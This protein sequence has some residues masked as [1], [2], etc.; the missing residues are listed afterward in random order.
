[1]GDPVI[2]TGVGLGLAVLA[3]W[4]RT[5]GERELT[6]VRLIF[7]RDIRPEQVVAF[8]RSLAGLLP[9]WWRRVF[10]GTPAVIFEVASDER[11]IRHRLIAAPEQAG[12]V[13][14]QLQAAVPGTR[15]EPEDLGPLEVRASAEL[16]VS[17]THV[18]LRT[19]QPE[20]AV[21]G[22]LA[23]LQPRRRGE[24]SVI[25]WVLSPAPPGGF[26]GSV[27][28]PSLLAEVTLG[29]GHVQASLPVERARA[30]RDKRSEPEAH[31]VCRLGVRARDPRREVQLLRRMIGAFYAGNA[32]GVSFRVRWLPTA[33][34]ARRIE[35]RGQGGWTA[36]LNAKE[37]AA[38]LGIPLGDLQ[39]PGLTLGGARQL[40][41]SSELPRRG[42][43]LGRST[44][45]G[46]ER[47]LALK[48]ADSLRHLHVIGPTG[49]GKSTLLLNLIAGDMAAGRG[50]VVIDPKGD[51]VGDVL[52]RVPRDRV[53]D[54]ILLDPNDVDRPA[55]LNLL[56]GASEAPELVTDQVVSVFHHLFSAFWGPRT[57]DIL[58][59]ALLTLAAEPGM[60]LVEVPLLLT[61]EA[62]RRR[63]VAAVDDPV[64]LE[65]FWG[66]YE[67]MSSAE[68]A[69]AIGP[70]LNKL[71][72]FLL[73]RRLRNVI[74]QAESTFDLEAVLAERKIL[75]VNLAKGLL[76]EEAAALL[77]SA[78]LARL[79]QAV[80]ARAALP[81]S[82]RTPVF[83][84][85]DEFQDYLNLP[86]SLADVLAQARGY[87][88]GLTLAHQ[89][90]GQL[91]PLVRTA[92]LAN[93]RSKV[94]FQTAASDAQTLAREFAP[95]LTP[96][97]LQALGPYE[98][99]VAAAASNRVL[100]PASM[101]TLPPT[102]PTGNG[103]EARERSR[104]RYGRDRADIERAMRTR[105]ETRPVAGGVKRRRR[106]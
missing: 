51:L 81:P 102:E 44:F 31:A 63:M 94:V 48:V 50:V 103:S 88:F 5:S 3:L 36:R 59:A 98:A 105:L 69:Q 71:R 26:R 14:S 37:L 56:A 67:A 21:A 33:V 13:L 68:R 46:D 64:A 92:V 17:S 29:V 84:Y 72:T 57:D 53:G 104:L 45:P 83:C 55:G 35:R 91:P 52:D 42:R 23:T 95:H 99:V 62:F 61:D 60:T 85:V 22:L 97:D 19:D 6:A 11:G 58:R 7:P 66:W 73:R 47:V 54:V 8:A 32:P 86:T 80:Q 96:A 76:G 15:V 40:A 10:G 2:L 28:L 4:V 20:Q 79:W 34:V 87:G 49:V 89:H 78:V 100:P 106:S 12:Y 93:A 30:E 41:A 77:G 16:R 90:L 65:P 27:P 39:L 25:Q 101:V 18:P 24:F 75:L 38:F 70:V 9:P 74:G 43:V 82:A 1:M